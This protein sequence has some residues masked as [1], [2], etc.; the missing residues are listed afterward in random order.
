MEGFKIETDDKKVPSAVKWGILLAG[1]GVALIVW[2]VIF[3][4]FHIAMG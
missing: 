2:L 1:L 3:M 4:V